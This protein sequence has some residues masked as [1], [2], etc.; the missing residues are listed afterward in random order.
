MAD[1]KKEGASPEQ[2]SALPIRY[3]DESS[4]EVLGSIQIEKGVVSTIASLAA[5][6]VEGIVGLVGKFSF[7]DMLGRKDVDK[8]VLVEIDGN[9]ATINVEVNVEY[10]VNIYDVCHRL[11]RKVKDSV[12]EM[13]GLVVDFV[14]V[15]VR[16]I[17]V[18]SRETKEQARAQT[19]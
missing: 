10:G 7:G 3:G 5:A 4:G 13:T 14:N 19:A 16:G 8:G 2:V 1:E 9:R 12:E 6:D 18:P 11:Q 17:A 15:S